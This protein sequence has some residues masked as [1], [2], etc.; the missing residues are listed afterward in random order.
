MILNYNHYMHHLQSIARL[1][2][3]EHIG[4]LQPLDEEQTKLLVID[5]LG[6]RNTEKTEFALYKVHE[7]LSGGSLVQLT[8]LYQTVGRK[9]AACAATCK[10]GLQDLPVLA[11]S[12]NTLQASVYGALK[13]ALKERGTS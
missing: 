9:N 11:T 4:D 2:L 6:G 3:L 7:M 13:M 8:S 5:I 10:T 12:F 1:D